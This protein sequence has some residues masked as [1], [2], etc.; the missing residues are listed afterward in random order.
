MN[1]LFILGFFLGDG[2]LYI[3]IRDNKKG[4]AFIPKFEIKQKNT[5]NS[6]KLMNKICEFWLNNGIQASLT[7]N[8]NYVLCFVEGMDNVCHKLLPFLEKHHEFFFWKKHQLEMLNQFAKLISLDTRNL[9][10]VKYL[11]IK[12]I[13][14]IDNNRNYTLEHWINRINEIFKEKSE[15]NLSGQ[16]YISPVKD[17]KAKTGEVVCWSVY[18]PAFINVKPRTKYFHFSKFGGN[19]EALNAA[20]VWRDGVIDNW[21]SEQGYDINPPVME[22]DE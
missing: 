22:Q 9:L 10:P 13:Y 6:E 18:L 14:S 19:N 15:K 7:V 1:I 12:T 3:R 17:K 21:L 16:F 8:E 20:M 5:F 2:C 4:L 11:L